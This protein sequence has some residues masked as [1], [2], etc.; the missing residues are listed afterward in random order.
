MVIKLKFSTFIAVF[1]LIACNNNK[2]SAKETQAIK[3]Q[4]TIDRN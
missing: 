2:Q 1:W 4:V 3:Q